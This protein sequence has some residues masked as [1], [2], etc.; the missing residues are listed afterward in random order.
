MK[1]IQL[2]VVAVAISSSSALYALAGY[3]EAPRAKIAVAAR[4]RTRTG[5][6]TVAAANTTTKVATTTFDPEKAWTELGCIGCHG[7]DGVYSDEITSALGKPVDEVGSWIRHAPEL[8]P[9]TEMP[10]FADRID[11]PSSVL[12]ARWVQDLAAHRK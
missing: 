10:Y 9:G 11:E 4:A 5:A 6:P 12:L 3:G 8:K 7:D 1:H 2:Y